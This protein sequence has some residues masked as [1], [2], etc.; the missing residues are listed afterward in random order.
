MTHAKPSEITVRLADRGDNEQLCDLFQRVTM[1][2]DLQLT[3]ERSPDFFALYAM[4]RLTGRRVHL[5]EV[6][7]RVEGV[8][9]FLCREAWLEGEPIRVGYLGDLRLSSKLRGGFFFGRRFGDGFREDL[10][11]LGCEV[12]LTGIIQTNQVAIR[13]LTRRSKRFTGAPVYRPWR[14]FDILNVHFTRRRRPRRTDVEVRRA[15]EED[16]AAIVELL[17]ADH[18]ARP[19]GY[20]FDEPL[21][22]H[23][24]AH[25]PGL[26]LSDFF[27]ALRSGRL[28]GVVAPWDAHAVKRF[29]VEAYRGSMRWIRAAFN[30]GALVWRYPA[31][32]PPGEGMR[33]C[34][35]THASVE[36]D[37]PLVWRALVDRVY[38]DLREA[39]YHFFSAFV[40]DG[41]PLGEAFARYTATPVPAQ[42]FTVSAPGSRFNEYDPGPG[43]PG[44]EMAL[45]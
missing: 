2:A 9:S 5:A 45:V 43:R 33:Y 34:Y 42:L 35:L 25:W 37:D 16:V 7:G 14:R 13:F 8:A 3:V 41:D 24:L 44:F 23:R 26:K 17:A 28:V 22:R 21:L 12:A 19:F 29:R 31:L 1:D 18:R 11:T 38:A 32:P 27:L 30:L 15:G 36:G 6:A 20:R 40:L 4:Q 39:G 10:E